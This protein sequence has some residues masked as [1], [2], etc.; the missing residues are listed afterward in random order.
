MK[1]TL[2]RSY[3]K[4]R[5]VGK[6]A[7]TNI[8]TLEP[9]WRDNKV[10][11]SCIPEGLYKVIRDKHGRFHYYRFEYVPGR[12]HIEMHQGIKPNNSDGC[13]LFGKDHDEQFDL[14]PFENPKQIFDVF[15]DSFW[16]EIRGY[17]IGDEW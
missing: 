8:Y 9:P 3:L 5:T 14:V 15:G 6:I 16:L 1:F 2:F 7:R 11:I 17:G 13:I 10:D 4:D 12:A